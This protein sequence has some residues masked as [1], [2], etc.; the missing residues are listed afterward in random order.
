MTRV[1]RSLPALLAAG[2][3]AAQQADPDQGAGASP[4]A[5]AGRLATVVDR[6]TP[7]E[8]L[9]G[10]DEL[11]AEADDVQAWLAACRAFGTFAELPVGASTREADLQV[12]D[13]VEK[14]ELHLYVPRS[15]DPAKPA[16]LL[17]WAH[18]QGG[19]GERQYTLWQQVAEQVGLIVLAPR[20]PNT[21]MG[22]SK[23]PRERAAAMAALRW[24]RRIANVDENAV[25]V[26]GWSRGGHLAWDL[27]LRY[28][29]HFAGALPV[30]GGPLMELSAAG[31]LRYL[32]NVLHLP[33]R[34]LQ[35]SGDDPR[36]L[37][38]LH[39][40]FDQLK[41]RKAADAQ[42]IEFAELGHSADLDAVDWAP[43]FEQTRREP[44]P[45]RVVRVAAELSEARQA[46]L[47]ITGFSRKVVLAPEPQVDARRWQRMDEARQVAYLLDALADY[48]ARLEVTDRGRGR[49]QADGFGIT[50]F[51]L[52]LRE[53]QLGRDGKVE[54]KLGRRTVKKQV[55]PSA[56]VLLEDFVERFD[57]TRLPVAR[58]VVP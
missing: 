32:D 50:S 55:E 23:E 42:L 38:N 22:F 14:T 16:P 49:F 41:K 54:V 1:H 11:L 53:E 47:R 51:E 58:V 48:T 27:M 12:L 44:W 21:G 26:G 20:D 8:R 43:F 29:D 36:L 3:L 25:F 30:V 39:L 2:V 4:D 46:W 45:Q 5:H 18:G 7:A 35:G 6:S 40:A 13:A 37:R 10:V 52:L 56:R 9:A 24:V 28:P 57:R 34:D 17:L 31:N 19:T 33:I 15:Y